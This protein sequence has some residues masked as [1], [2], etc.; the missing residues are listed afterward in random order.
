MPIQYQLS[1]N[2][3]A[4]LRRFKFGSHDVGRC[5]DKAVSPCSALIDTGTT[6]IW[7]PLSEGISL[8]VILSES[9]STLKMYAFRHSFGGNSEV[10]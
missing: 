6:S 3:I 1:S 5:D 4:I 10:N 9:V 2:H 7:V 8:M